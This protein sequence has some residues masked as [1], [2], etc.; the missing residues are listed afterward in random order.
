MESDPHALFCLD[1]S[2]TLL[3]RPL[4]GQKFVHFLRGAWATDP[5]LTGVST[6]KLQSGVD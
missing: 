4:G 1:L 5:P 3:F 2:Y 6:N